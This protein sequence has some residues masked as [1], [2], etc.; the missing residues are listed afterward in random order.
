MMAQ[1]TVLMCSTC[2]SNPCKK[3]ELRQY[4]RCIFDYVRATQEVQRIKQS[5]R[6]RLART[7]QEFESALRAVR[8]YEDEIIPQVKQSLELSE[9]AY[10]AESSI[11]S[12]FWSSAEA[13]TKRRYD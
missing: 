9:K 8:K 10:Q 6:S 12:K 2:G 13:T 11:S 4:L 7:A 5:V 1:I 3:Q